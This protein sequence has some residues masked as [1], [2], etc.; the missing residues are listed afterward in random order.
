VLVRGKKRTTVGL[1]GVQGR[2]PKMLMAF[3]GHHLILHE[4]QH[5]RTVPMLTKLAL[6]ECNCSINLPGLCMDVTLYLNEQ[7]QSRALTTR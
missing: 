6:S 4:R 7:P 3:D 5:S 2:E 1:C